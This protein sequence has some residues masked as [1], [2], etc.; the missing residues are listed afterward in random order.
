MCVYYAMT[1]E[2]STFEYTK[3]THTH[4]HS[5]RIV[6]SV[7][8]LSTAAVITYTEG[9]HIFTN[10]VF[11]DPK[12]VI[13]SHH[14]QHHKIGHCACDANINNASCRFLRGCWICL[15]AAGTLGP[16]QMAA[17]DSFIN[18]TP[19]SMCLAWFILG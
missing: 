7:I 13:Y 3:C 1:L 18:N 19:S 5:H 16:I 14:H 2:S 17:C 12:K 15:V 6:Y 10:S 11:K 9:N 8:T 4:T